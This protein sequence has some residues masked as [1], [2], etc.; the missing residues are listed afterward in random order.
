[1]QFDGGRKNLYDLS[2][3]KVVENDLFCVLNVF[4]IFLEF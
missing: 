4:G 2:I 1:M 3:T